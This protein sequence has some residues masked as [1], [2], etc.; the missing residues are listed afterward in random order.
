M[1]YSAVIT[2][3]ETL[4]VRT[5]AKRCRSGNWARVCY[6]MLHESWRCWLGE[7]GT[8][9][10]QVGKQALTCTPH[11]N[12]MRMLAR[13]T[14][15]L[16]LQWCFRNSLHCLYFICLI[17]HLNNN[18]HFTCQ[19]RLFTAKLFTSMNWQFCRCDPQKTRFVHKRRARSSSN[20]KRRMRR[21]AVSATPTRLPRSR[22]RLR[23]S[24]APR[25]GIRILLHC[26]RPPVVPRR[27][28]AHVHCKE[29]RKEMPCVPW[30]RRVW[31]WGVRLYTAVCSVLISLALELGLISLD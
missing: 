19:K 11:K 17:V 25:R 15:W 4:M 22:E 3:T 5:K 31:L 14:G 20:E 1:V 28:V 13:M 8:A 6:I 16:Y 29:R 9:A 30:R 18:F 7:N 27:L 2:R 23:N 24:S 26:A 21:N 10:G 12:H